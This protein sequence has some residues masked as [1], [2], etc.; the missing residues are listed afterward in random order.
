MS[1][2]R[3]ERVLVLGWDGMRPGAGGS[4]VGRVIL[5]ITRIA[6]YERLSD[7]LGKRFP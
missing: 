2:A 6:D 3:V 4:G 7:N 5:G 1:A